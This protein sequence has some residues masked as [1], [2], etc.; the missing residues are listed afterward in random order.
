MGVEEFYA[1]MAAWETVYQSATTTASLDLANAM[2]HNNDQQGR[3]D[4][5]LGLSIQCNDLHR[6]I[7]DLYAGIRHYFGYDFALWS[8]T[9]LMD[10]VMLAG[11]FADYDL[12]AAKIME[13]WIETTKTERLMTVLTLDSLR[14]DVWGE[15][16]Q[17]YNI[18]AASGP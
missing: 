12:T 17:Y 14:Q 9:M 4:D 16:F 2:A 3:D 6:A 10:G 13:A 7:D 8:S 11:Y 5:L 15:R 1:D 18:K